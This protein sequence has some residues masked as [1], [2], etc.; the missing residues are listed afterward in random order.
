MNQILAPHQV[1]VVEE[2]DQLQEKIIALAKFLDAVDSQVTVIDSE[3]RMRLVSQLQFMKG[4]ISV[5]R[6]RISKFGG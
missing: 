5:L 2:C 6:W 3:E 4:Y 1:R